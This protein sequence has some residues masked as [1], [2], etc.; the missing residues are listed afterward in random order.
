MRALPHLRPAA[1]GGQPTN[2]AGASS[3]L[4][5]I[6]SILAGIFPIGP[7]PWTATQVTMAVATA[8]EIAVDWG[9]TR[10]ALRRGSRETNPVLGARPS[11]G[12]LT[13]YNAFAI[14]GVVV[15]GALLTP[16]LRTAWFATLLVVQTACVIRNA[17]L[18]FH[19]AF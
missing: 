17:I 8:S 16:S 12:R 2:Y 5:V 11:S 19:I 7:A 6:L 3:L 13:A 14:S 9:Q 1:H 4:R 10:D 15:V 18:G